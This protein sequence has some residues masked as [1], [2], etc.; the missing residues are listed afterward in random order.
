MRLITSGLAGVSRVVERLEYVDASRGQ[1]DGL[2]VLADL[3]RLG[4]AQVLPEAWESLTADAAH[5]VE[6]VAVLGAI[7]DDVE[8]GSFF[9]L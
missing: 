3:Q 1:R 2:P 6:R 5:G 4:G 8:P 7:E 9:E